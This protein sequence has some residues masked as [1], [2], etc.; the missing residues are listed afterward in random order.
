MSSLQKSNAK[1]LWWSLLSLGL[2]PEIAANSGGSSKRGITLGINMFD[3]PNKDAFYVVA[4][5]L[6]EKLNPSRVNEVFRHCWP[7]MG[8][9][10]DAEFRK[11]TYNWFREI[12]AE[13]GNAFPKVV[14]SL[15]LSPGGP[16][17]I[18]VMLHL[19]KHV[20]LQEMKT[21][22]T[23]K[24]WIPEASAAKAQSLEMAM[25]RFQL[26]RLRFQRTAVEQDQLIQEY[27]RKARA[28]VKSIRDLRA[29]D[30]QLDSFLKHEKEGEEKMRLQ[31][32]KILK[33]RSLWTD[34][35]NILS[36]LEEERKVV[37]CVVKGNIDQYTLDG[38]DLTINI[39]KVLL[40]QVE[41]SA[42][43]S[44]TGSVYEEGQLNV[45][46]LLE[47]L[48]EAL[49]LLREER[50]RVGG[51]AP[52]PDLQHME[53]KALLLRRSL[54]A[55]RLTRKRISKE[56]IPEVKAFIQKM[57]QAWDRKWEDSLERRPLTSF[58]NEDPALDFLSPMA[59][60]CFEPAAE[61]SFKSSVFSLYPAKLPAP[62]VE[63]VKE[64]A[65]GESSDSSENADGE[66][67]DL[68][69]LQ[70]VCLPA[71]EPSET[72]APSS[73]PSPRPSTPCK[74][75]SPKPFQASDRKTAPA[76]GTRQKTAAVEKAAMIMDRE[77]DNLAEQFADGVTASPDYSRQGMELEALL[78]TLLDPFST[79]KQIPRT[80]ESLISEVKNSWRRAL[81]EG[82][83]EKAQLSGS[84]RDGTSDASRTR[85]SA[86]TPLPTSRLAWD[87]DAASP[88]TPLPGQPG[89][90]LHSTLSW[91]SAQLDTTRG[92][93]GSSSDVI[94]FGIACETIPELLGGESILSSSDGVPDTP[95]LTEEEEEGENELGLMEEEEENELVLP[96]IPSSAADPEAALRSRFS[97]IRKDY[98]ESSF[99]HRGGETPEPPSPL[100]AGS[101]PEAGDWEAGSRVFSL[102][103]DALE[104]PPLSSRERLSLPKLA[105]FSPIDDLMP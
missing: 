65:P 94:H 3:T 60:L 92:Q 25:L 67:A 62:T 83:A 21:F 1:Y 9:K 33:V 89:D 87:A 41:K 80:P 11:A 68:E 88:L 93:S 5:F 75:P 8:W 78:G 59:P 17:F 50:E 22:S 48:N 42:Q 91:D 26:V 86:D 7:V 2:Q 81:E 39:P 49:R 70:S 23:D 73:V 45:L 47:L 44:S 77:W 76:G 18:N 35:N 53:E 58:L 16:K 29:E 71:S 90:S 55:V 72:P 24:T 101:F 36:T 66:T 82:E 63:S 40:E 27:Q 69:D 57:E 52:R 37:D 13:R 105:T 103:L 97:R 74:A 51:A 4:H 6:F 32:E 84:P 34:V 102:D 31:S 98:C 61:G 20:M 79:R 10:A 28:L 64:E 100:N 99:T 30:A 15:F 43:S 14:A 46:R 95:G 19:A 85:P 38:T 12:G 96:K 56:D 104:S 54:E